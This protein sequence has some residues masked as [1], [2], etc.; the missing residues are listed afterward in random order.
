MPR[1]SCIYQKVGILTILALLPL[2]F[3]S[4]NQHPHSPRTVQTQPDLV[5]QELLTTIKNAE[6]LGERNALLISTLYSLANFYQ[7]HNEYERAADQY[8]RILSIKEHLNGPNHPDIAEI[9]NR[10]AYVLQEAKRTSE[11]ANLIA[12]AQSILAKAER[13]FPPK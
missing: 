5:E 12:R 7:D 2:M 1:I 3:S 8:H 11:A 13:T 4:C 10:Y 6:N 9:L